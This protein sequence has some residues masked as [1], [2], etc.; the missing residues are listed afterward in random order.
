[1]GATLR[2]AVVKETHHECVAI[3]AKQEV[4][5]K[6]TKKPKNQKKKRHELHDLRF[7][8]DVKGE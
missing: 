7:I 6:K 4:P 8:G 3:T 5:Q 2:Q 1:M